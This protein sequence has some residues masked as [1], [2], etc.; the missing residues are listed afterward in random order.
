MKT[1]SN[2]IENSTPQIQG[3]NKKV[4][5]WRYGIDINNIERDKVLEYI[6]TKLHFYIEDK[7]QDSD[8][9]EL[10][11]KDFKDFSVDIFKQHQRE[12]QRLRQVLRCGGVFVALNTKSITIA[13]CVAE[14]LGEEE[15]HVWTV[16]DLVEAEPDLRRGPILSIYIKPGVTGFTH[17][18][19][20]AKAPYAQPQS[21]TLYTP[22]SLPPA[23][24]VPQPY[25]QGTVQASSKLISEVAKI[26]TEE[27]KYNG[28][29]GSFDLKLAIFLDICQRV[30][31][32]ASCL[33][34]AFPTMLKGLALDHFY[35]N[36][37]SGL[38][39][40]EAC[41]STRNFFEGPGYQRRNLDKW[42]SISLSSITAENPNKNVYKNIQ[43][44]IN[45]L[46]QL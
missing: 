4:K 15:Q 31:L 16:A 32:P 11:H 20:Q 45:T 19:L 34:R 9:W 7:V 35:N 39:Y 21:Q 2:A 3:W 17:E 1:P 12:T 46:Q 23:P 44:L 38:T 42:N 18:K 13:Q 41:S 40:E 36:Q 27:Q 14:V 37:L 24:A 8:L 25:I 29:N 6:Q 28:I 26:Y 22:T 43:M 33:L 5:K 30:D 10:F